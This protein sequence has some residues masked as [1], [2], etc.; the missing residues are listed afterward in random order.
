M[1]KFYRILAMLLTIIMLATTLASCNVS[2]IISGIVNPQDRPNPDI[3][4][5]HYCESKCPQC[6]KCLDK[7]C[8]EVTCA[9]KCPGHSSTPAH[10]CES[11]CPD[12]GKC[13]DAKCTESVCADKCAGHTQAHECES[14][15]PDCG[16]CLDKNC[17]EDDCKE[18][19]EGHESGPVNASAYSYM[20]IITEQ[21]PAIYINTPDG[22]NSWVTMYNRNDKINGLIDYVDATISVGNCDTKYVIT[23]AEAEVKVRGNYTLEYPKKPIRIKFAKS[24]KTNLLGLHDGEEYRNWVL[25]ADWKD[26]SM[27]NN[28]L[29]F[30]LG[31]TIL[32]S[33]GY[34]CT[35]FRNVEVYLNGQ[36]WGVYLLVEQQEVKDNRTSVPEVDDD[37][38]G[39]D[40]GYLFEY[41]GYYYLETEAND[42]DPTFTMTYP[43]GA[44][45]RG[46]I[47][48]TIKSDIYADSQI[49]FLRTYMNNAYYI[50]FEATKGNFYKFDENYNVVPDTESGTAKQVVSKVIDVK[51]LVDIY[52]LN[53]I[54]CDLDVDWSSFYLSLDMSAEGN[55]KVTF[56]APWDWDSCFG[57]RNGV[58]N[59]AQGLYASTKGNPWFNL[60]KNESWYQDMIREKWAEMKEYG[61]LDN[62]FK[63]LNAEKETY[64]NYYIANYERWS[65]RVYQGNG[66]CNGTLNSYKDINTAQGLAADYLINWLAAR[67]EF[68]DSVWYSYEAKLPEAYDPAP[69][70]R[71][72]MAAIYINTPSDTVNSWAT[73]FGQQ[74]KIN[75]LIDYVDATITVKNCEEEFALTDAEAEVKLRGNATLNYEKKPIRIKLAKKAKTSLLGLH[76]GEE[77]RNWV[78]LA[79]YKDLSMM[80]NSLAFYLGNAIL[81]SDGYYCTD[82]RS[83][84]VYLNGQYWGVYLLV[85]QQE[86]KDGRSSVPEVEEDYEGT[87]IGYFFE[88]DGYYYQEGTSYLDGGEGDPTF[89]MSYPSG[90]TYRSGIG[91]TV[92]SDLYT[93]DQLNFLKSYLEKAFT[94]AYEATKGN[95]YKFDENYNIVSNTSAKSAKAVIASVIDIQSLV[96]TYIL[97]E[98]ACDLDVDWSSFYLSL[99]M[100]AEG[101]KKITF[102]AP[103]DWDSCFGLR[104]NINNKVPNAQGMYAIAQCNNPWLDLVANQ[105]WFW[106][107]VKA[108][109]ADM[110]KN[111]VLENTIE[112]LKSEK[113]TYKDY[114][115]KNYERWPNR[116]TQGNGE[117]NDTLNSYRDIQ[118][119]QGLAADWLINWITKRFTFLDKQW[120]TG[121][122]G[123]IK[124]DENLPANSV[125]YKF[126]AEDAALA[127]FTD[128]API[129]TNRDYASGS[130]YVGGT[131]NGATITFTINASEDTTVYL[132]AAVSKMSY[133]ASFDTWFSITVNGEELLLPIRNVDAVSGGEE[134]WHTFISV[135]LAPIVLNEGEN[136]IVFNC[137][138]ERNNLDYIE[139]YSA[140]ELS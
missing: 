87:D 33:D 114:Y 55:K 43:N 79:D 119:A 109:W 130:A 15:C 51:S 63:M 69:V 5:P 58:V 128:S 28:S 64:K 17:T 73:K 127:N 27:M 92:K 84:E 36:Y 48:Y 25:L 115:I 70:I 99:N 45:Y 23:D 24:A 42:G 90:A 47:G 74:D 104:N 93:K 31:N 131:I 98:I 57:L 30:Y 68:L 19:C 3:D 40:I 35:D 75:G 4:K 103:W 118:T 85:E 126:E 8:T 21:M 124:V 2:D 12:C 125:A 26:L 100:T 59:N 94:I 95:Y 62:A 113:E 18:K 7:A 41:D 14:V 138:P 111:N 107:M 32:G 110:V 50:A 88:Y 44:S 117:C 65:E 101:N 105:D 60:L 1:K 96:D 20:P 46:D 34:Y 89:T 54:A 61:V 108:K 139:L 132:F 80:N 137:L 129:R 106:N 16:K 67:F 97:N 83:V 122:F 121:E 134:A 76:D 56:E 102:E 49:E 22:D 135:K 11:V 77:Y 13:L 6:G 140:T 91:Y 123:S 81:E 38:T 120:G 133:S 116:V 112:F 78:L 136:T 82:F 66:E 9:N 10:T 86:A 52:I 53:E 72:E 29:A 71:E 37:Y 39:N